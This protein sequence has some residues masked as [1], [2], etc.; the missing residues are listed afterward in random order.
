MHS[1]GVVPRKTSAKGFLVS[2]QGF[3]WR[4]RAWLVA[5]G[6]LAIGAFGIGERLLVGKASTNLT[7]YVPW[8]LWVSVYVFLIWLEVGG[9]LIFSAL[10]HGFRWH[11]LQPIKPIV[12]LTGLVILLMALV[13][14]AL[15]LG[16]PFRAWRVFVSPNFNSPMTWMIWLHTFY[17]ALLVSELSAARFGN[18]RL[19]SLLS[20]VTFPTGLLLIF[21]VGA[22]FGFN[23]A[24]PIW[25]VVSMPL[26]FLMAS[27]SAGVA[28]VA[29]HIWL[30]ADRFPDLEADRLLRRLRPVVLGFLLTGA[31]AALM[32]GLMLVVPQIPQHVTALRLA[33]FGPYWWS[34]WGL[35]VALGVVIPMGILVMAR[36]PAAVALASVLVVAGFSAVPPNLIIPAL[37]TES[38]VGLTEAY[39]GARLSLDYFPSRAEWLT[40]CF[41]VGAGWLL[42]LAGLRWLLVGRQQE[43]PAHG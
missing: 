24:R 39:Q 33:L 31:C 16:H 22:I 20:R 40:L 7:S 3:V 6:L 25:N 10:Y 5:A 30:F 8:G 23:A 14:I 4:Y 35:H 2:A 13:I 27:L 37:A 15:D 36:S 32:T 18:E 21:T 12:Y 43:G 28:L 17:L 1:T 41:I 26:H 11:Q 29:A 42:F 34:F 19:G 38:L 9:L